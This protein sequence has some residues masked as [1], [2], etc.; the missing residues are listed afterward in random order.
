MSGPQESTV[1]K[2]LNDS[3]LTSQDFS[4]VI[5]EVGIIIPALDI[6]NKK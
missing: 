2:M 3:H 4:F 6:S 1:N 5:H